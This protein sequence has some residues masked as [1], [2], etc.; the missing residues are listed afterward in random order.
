MI[1]LILFDGLFRFCRLCFQAIQCV[2]TWAELCSNSLNFLGFRSNRSRREIQLCLRN[3]RSVSL[4]KKQ[5]V[6]WFL[7]CTYQRVF[8]Q[9]SIVCSFRFT[10]VGGRNVSVFTCAK[11]F[12]SYAQNCKGWRR[13]V[14]TRILKIDSME[15]VLIVSDFLPFLN[16]NYMIFRSLQNRTFCWR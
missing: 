8:G 11:D 5:E 7:I 6:W 9:G 2:K 14:F 10:I 1:F 13:F 4:D 15:F 12:F 16:I 3:S